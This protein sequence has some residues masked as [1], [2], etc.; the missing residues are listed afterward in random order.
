MKEEERGKVKGRRERRERKRK[1]KEMWEEEGKWGKGKITVSYHD[2]TQFI[3]FPKG[4][5]VLSS[6]N[7]GP[8]EA[9]KYFLKDG[10][11][12]IT[13]HLGAQTLSS[14]EELFVVFLL[15]W[16]KPRLWAHW[17]LPLS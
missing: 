12:Y 9:Q 13:H 16:M 15:C 8:K 5:Q 11:C 17:T 1:R 14:R 10:T 2:I 3:L 6:T 4:L 7:K